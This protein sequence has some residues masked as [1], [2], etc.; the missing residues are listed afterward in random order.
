MSVGKL[1][2]SV[3]YSNPD[4]MSELRQQK[5]GSYSKKSWLVS[6]QM[7]FNERSCQQSHETVWGLCGPRLFEVSLAII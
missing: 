6:G 4:I 3:K 1:V 7:T 2:S 5:Q